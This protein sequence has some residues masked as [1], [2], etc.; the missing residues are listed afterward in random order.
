MLAFRC[1][2]MAGRA[3]VSTSCSGGNKSTTS[4]GRTS[5]SGGMLDAKPTRH[6]RIPFHKRP[7]SIGGIGSGS[8]ATNASSTTTTTTTVT[9][10]DARNSTTANNH[11]NQ[12]LVIM[13]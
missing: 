9:G 1:R 10:S 13:M 8:P 3:S 12:R 4:C 5:T 2:K 7:S 6:A 11:T